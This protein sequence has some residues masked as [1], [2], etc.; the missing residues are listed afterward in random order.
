MDVVLS[1]SSE[2]P[3]QNKTIKK[4]LDSKYDKPE[5][6]IPLS[7]ID[8]G[9]SELINHGQTA[10]TFLDDNDFDF[11]QIFII[12]YGEED[13]PTQRIEEAYQQGFAVFC[14]F[15][16]TYDARILPLTYRQ[17]D[18][19]HVFSIYDTIYESILTVTCDSDVWSSS[20]D[21]II[22]SPSLFLDGNPSM[23]GQAERGISDNYA[24]AD[25]VHPHDTTK[26]DASAVYTKTEIDQ[27]LVGVMNYKG[28]KPYVY[29]LPL[30]GN[31]KGDVWHVT[32][33]GSEW[34]WN[35]SAWEELGKSIDFSS[36]RTAAEQDAIDENQND[37]I[38]AKYT[39]PST[40]IPKTDLDTAVQTSLGKAD[41]AIQ[42]HQDISGKLDKNQG[43]AHAGEFCVVGADGNIITVTMTAWQGGSY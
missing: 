32:D 40:G 39:K 35:G 30:T 28:T 37:S 18:F 15:E 43:A 8:D 20:H 26:A 6:G 24:R 10:Y 9:L 34:A 42:Q 12:N 38:N 29:A 16:G 17:S 3:V 19:I 1:N 7:D 13:S 33:D 2:N 27:K 36:Y 5:H 31:A 23:N 4:A 21:K 22:P 41:T 11:R 25:H 14:R